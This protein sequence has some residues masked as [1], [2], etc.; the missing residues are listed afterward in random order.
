MYSQPCYEFFDLALA[1]AKPIDGPLFTSPQ[2][3]ALRWK[4]TEQGAF[5]FQIQAPVYPTAA[6]ALIQSLYQQ[7][8]R[9]FD[10]QSLCDLLE[11]PDTHRHQVRWVLSCLE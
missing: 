4:I 9:S 1:N 7:G 10:L 11:C 6:M 5:E 2:G 8:Q 3:D